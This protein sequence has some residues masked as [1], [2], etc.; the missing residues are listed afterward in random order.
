VTENIQPDWSDAPPWAQWWAADK[1]GPF[2]YARKPTWT[3]TGWDPNLGN[4]WI[5][6]QLSGV[7]PGAWPDTLRRRP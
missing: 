7:Q 4:F 6:P 2:W 1:H 5:A 3:G